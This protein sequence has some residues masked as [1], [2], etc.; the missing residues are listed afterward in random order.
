MFMKTDWAVEM[1]QKHGLYVILDMHGLPGGQSMDHK[2]TGR[3]QL[4]IGPRRPGP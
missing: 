2:A 4:G 1:A 3:F